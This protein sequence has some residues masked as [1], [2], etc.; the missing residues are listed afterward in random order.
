[1]FVFTNNT[2]KIVHLFHYVLLMPHFKEPIQLLSCLKEREANDIFT[3]VV[4]SDINQNQI[5]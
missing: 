2:Y 5:S 1:M 3:S 4:A